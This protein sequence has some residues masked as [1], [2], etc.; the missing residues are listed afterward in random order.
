[1]LR[2]VFV[3]RVESERTTLKD[4]I[5]RYISEITPAHKGRDSETL[6]LKRLSSA[7][8]RSTVFG[9]FDS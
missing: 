3:S 5:D 4:L 9:D 6:R 1:M 7:R 8:T 2:G